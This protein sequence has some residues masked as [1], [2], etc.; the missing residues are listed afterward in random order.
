MF[1][2]PH[3][4]PEKDVFH[5]LTVTEIL[6][7]TKGKGLTLPFG[8]THGKHAALIEVILK[9]SPQIIESI[10]EAVKAKAAGHSSRK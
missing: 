5:G 9:E 1:M 2:N 6:D 8:I 4:Q 10:K 3:M 7:I